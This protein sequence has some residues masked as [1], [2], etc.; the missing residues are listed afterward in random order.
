MHISKEQYEERV[1]SLISKLHGDCLLLTPKE[2]LRTQLPSEVTSIT[3]WPQITKHAVFDSIISIGQLAISENLIEFLTRLQHYA[4]RDSLLYFCDRTIVPD[5]RKG[6]AKNDITGSFWQSEWS[7]I[8]CERF[9]IGQYKRAPRYVF[10]IAR[11]KRSND[12]HL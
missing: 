8:R 12:E 4:N 10:G 3:E 11:V 9:A 5:M 7:V 2:N 1:S 6:A